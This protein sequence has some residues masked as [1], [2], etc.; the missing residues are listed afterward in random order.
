MKKYLWFVVLNKYCYQYSNNNSTTVLYKN[1]II[2]QH[3]RAWQALT[4]QGHPIGRT[5]N[6]CGPSSRIL[7]FVKHHKYLFYLVGHV[8]EFPLHICQGLLNKSGHIV[9]IFWVICWDT[10]TA[11]YIRHSRTW[12]LEHD[13]R[14]L[15]LHEFNYSYTCVSIALVFMRRGKRKIRKYR[16]GSHIH[17]PEVYR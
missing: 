10:G 5:L 11:Q 15:E 6:R 4:F 9:N 13:C 3:F 16:T 14:K 17:K 12:L 2:L 1:R 8:C 7:W